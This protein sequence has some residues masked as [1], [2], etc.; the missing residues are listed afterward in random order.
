M[1]KIK[2]LLQVVFLILSLS[3]SLFSLEFSLEQNSTDKSN[4]SA[5]SKAYFGEQIFQG[6]FKENKQFR[7][8]PDYLINIGDIV[9][10]KLWGAFEFSSDLTVDQQGNIFIPKIGE[11][12]LLGLSN[13]SL[14]GTIESEVKKTFNNNVYVYAD[15]KQYQLL[16]VF[17]SGG[18]KKVGLYN[19]LSTDSILQYID[20]AGGIVRGQG[21][22]R[23]ISILR[24]KQVI[25]NIDLYQFLLSGNIDSFQFKNGDVIL[26]NSVKNFI[27]VEGDV[28]RPY[29]FELFSSQVSVQEVMQFIMPKPTAN[30]FM[31][32]SWSNGQESTS[33]YLLA[34]A[35]TTFISNG[36][37]LK[38]F[39]DYYVNNMEIT[40]EGE[41]KGSKQI[42]VEKGTTLYQILGKVEF[43]PLSEIKNIR[44][45]RKSVATIQKQ[46]IENMLKDLEARV[47]TSGS[48]TVEE[49][50]IRTK[51]AE[52]VMQFIAR[53]RAVQPL[54]Q[55]VMNRKDSL[56]EIYLE[57]GDRIVIPK[58][59]SVVVIQG[60]VNIPNAIAYRSQY[61]INDYIKV[62]G[63]YSE[64]ANLENILLIKA[65]GEVLQYNHGSF[66]G[67]DKAPMVESGDSILVLGKTDSKN[68]LIASS[69]TKIL[70]QVAVGAAVVLRAF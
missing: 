47:L 17:V 52:M 25:K 50:S 64:R 58:R 3:S 59:S 32:T 31:L 44:L 56:N 11:V 61:E 22:F 45:Y 55:V 49:A 67:G 18:V 33:N 14:K 26:V 30:S 19:G 38:F 35:S 20:K 42:T 63:G 29:I 54:G 69:L 68:I 15:I 65:N 5:T 70:Y 13:Q 28:N 6:N 12:N 23:N 27:E 10:V 16:S 57:E 7:Y 21:S 37:K 4:I 60:E 41:H 43:T 66:F 40:L 34:K 62:C 24:D 2:S 53:A 1:N 39:S 9:S 46:L 51:E 48:A 36:G 8:N